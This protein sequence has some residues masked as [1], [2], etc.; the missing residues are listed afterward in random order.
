MGAEEGRGSPAQGEAL[1]WDAGRGRGRGDER[2]LLGG[3]GVAA[4]QLEAEARLSLGRERSRLGGGGVGAI[5]A[6]PRLGRRGLGA[7]P[8]RCH[9]PVDVGADHATMRAGPRKQGEVDV[10]LSGEPP[11]QRRGLGA[12]AR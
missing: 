7:I 10:E 2:E 5:P 3:T 12:A 4:R 8:G 1:Q 6:R 11:C 9:R